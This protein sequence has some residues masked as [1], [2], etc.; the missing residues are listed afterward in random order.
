MRTILAALMRDRDV[1]VL[2]CA[3]VLVAAGSSIHAQD[4]PAQ[5]GV[6]SVTY[7]RDVAPIIATRCG[8][9]H[10]PGGDAPFSLSTFD[11]VRRRGAMIVAVTRSRFMP[12]WKPA[13]GFGEFT[14]ARRL[15]AHEI[16]TL[17]QWVADGTPRGTRS[18]TGS[19]SDRLD[20]PPSDASGGWGG[21][22]PDLIVRVTPY[23][24]RADGPDVFRIFSVR[25]PIATA[26]F[27]QGIYFRPGNRAVHHANIRVDTTSASRMLDEADPLPGYEGMIA[28]AADFPD[29]HF[30]GWTPGQAAPVLSEALAW[31]LEG[32]ADLAVQLHLRPSGKTEEIAPVIGLYF[33]AD[34]SATPPTAIRLGRQ[35]LDVPAGATHHIVT[36]SFVL[37]VD[38]KVMAVQPH[39]HYR[40]R[41]MDAWATLPDGERRPLIRITDWDM[42]WQDRYL[43]A[44][45]FWLPAGTRLSVEYV[46]DNSEANPRN[47]DRPP[48]R[49]TWG[50]RSNDEMADLWIQV[51]T[52][53]DDDRSRLRREIEFKMQSEDTIGSEVL[54]QREPNHVNLRN[55]AAGLYLSL[56]QPGTALVHF[57]AVR[58]LR[59]ESAAAWFN[60]GVAL[61]AAGRSGEARARYAEALA[62]DPAYSQ[63]HNNLA[64]LLLKD[65]RVAEARAG[66]ERA[67]SADPKNADARANLALVL[68]GTAETDAAI[69]QVAYVLE[70]KPELVVGLTPVVWL[71]AAHPEPAARRPADAR[72][73]AER[74]VA[75]TGRGDASALDALAACQAALG[76]FEEAVRVASEAESATPANQPALRQAI[77]DRLTLYR[78]GKAYT[79]APF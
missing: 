34:R 71:L 22:P 7:T 35:D 44:D 41:A 30:L 51:L 8:A 77:R 52:R 69:T 75:A 9:C 24:L 40:T 46:F 78:A 6:R 48:T 27:V 5:P 16:A 38:A 11:E 50:W 25:V 68:A 55:D 63:A 14:G 23:T 18:D 61:D 65:G 58:A 28:R 70:Q 4:A 26:R 15:Q 47:P 29:G 31:R 43:Y 20:L 12:P 17:E 76:R 32:G 10:V 33:G 64:A 74:I 67:V 19:S 73:L 66:F 53:T 49:A 56:G 2:T 21:R 42:N 1:W 37:P 13:P 57:A 60:E 72:R 39:A 62:R 3:L 45:P 79:L 36:D 59:P 54:L